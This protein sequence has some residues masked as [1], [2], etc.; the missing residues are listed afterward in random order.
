MWLYLRS[1]LFVLIW[2]CASFQAVSAAE[3]LISRNTLDQPGGV[4]D[5]ELISFIGRGDLDRLKEKLASIDVDGRPEYD[6][7]VR[8]YLKSGAGVLEDAL[9]I[10]RYLQEEGIST[11]V[12]ADD[13]CYWVCSILFMHGTARAP[14]GSTQ[15]DRSIEP[16]AYLGFAEPFLWPAPDH[17]LMSELKNA[18][19]TNAYEMG[20][21]AVAA[22][23]EAGEG[24]INRQLLRQILRSDA[25][26]T[27][28]AETVG[29]LI[30]WDV[31]LAEAPDM[32]SLTEN[33]LVL[34]CENA[35]SREQGRS[36]E[37][38]LRRIRRYS[39]TRRPNLHKTLGDGTKWYRI[40]VDEDLP[41][42]CN[43]KV[44]EDGDT[45]R[46]ELLEF[47]HH[48]DDIPRE[49]ATGRQLPPIYLLEPDMR[50]YKMA[51]G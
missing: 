25:S 17:P 18:A 7:R 4:V 29:D 44:S 2:L 42:I 12:R 40:V 37:T 48:P 38:T 16:G 36:S 46:L 43:L 32:P 39:E 8:L 11:R 45:I 23:I 1:I 30:A 41:A 47:S 35:W 24:V 5:I 13:Y 22:L 14:D 51:K 34:A 19:I 10:A 21:G 15:A 27:L 28:V 33:R 49:P 3:I 9:D 26:D 31:G 20:V 50:L 6:G